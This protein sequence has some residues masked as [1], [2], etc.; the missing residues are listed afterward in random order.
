[1][2]V[3][4][5]DRQILDSIHRFDGIM[6]DYQIDRRFFSGQG[7]SQFRL[8]MSFL[9]KEKYVKKTS[10]SG[11]CSV[12]GLTRK[13]AR[14]VAD[15]RHVR[16]QHFKYREQ[17]KRGPLGHHLR[18][19]DFRLDVIEAC[20]LLPTLEL[21]QWIAEG[22][23]WS[24]PDEVTYRL[25]SGEKE[26]RQVI[27]DGFMVIRQRT[28][29]GTLLRYRL[30]LEIDRATETIKR[31][32][33]EKILAATAYLRSTTYQERFGHPSGRWLWVTTS[34]ERALNLKAEVEKTAGPD[35]RFF[36]FSS[37]DQVISTTLFT[38]PVWYQGGEEGQGSLITL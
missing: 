36:L 26:K 12:Y 17:P 38:T 7:G 18:V 23:F 35:A 2:I 13:G 6:A 30:L 25:P 15:F 5:R 14:T 31:I 19:N 33:Q 21:E 37:F 32:G 3:T 22:E 24:N 29:G 27:P 9:T 16:F 11:G 8:R 20:D 28:R 1:V 34:K 10:A 4:E